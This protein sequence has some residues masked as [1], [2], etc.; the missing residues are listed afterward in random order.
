MPDNYRE[1]KKALLFCLHRAR[2]SKKDQRMQ[3]RKESTMFKRLTM[4]A[5]EKENATASYNI[6]LSLTRGAIGCADNPFKHKTIL[7][8]SFIIL[9]LVSTDAKLWFEAH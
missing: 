9:L 5:S 4:V 1:L 7:L 8:L 3:G 6:I 2:A